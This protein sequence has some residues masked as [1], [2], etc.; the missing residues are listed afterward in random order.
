M[1]GMVWHLNWSGR[2][3]YRYQGPPGAAPI[4]APPSIYNFIKIAFLRVAL[5]I[6]A[7]P[8]DVDPRRHDALEDRIW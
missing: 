1:P 8:V 5:E 6:L 2:K 3:V 4:K 7:D